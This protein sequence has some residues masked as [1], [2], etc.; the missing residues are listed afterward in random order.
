[1]SK[2]KEFKYGDNVRVK[3]PGKRA[4][5]GKVYSQYT[6]PPSSRYI[7]VEHPGGAGIAYLVRYVTNLT[8]R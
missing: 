3:E 8:A 1:M 2:E 5:I 7:C 6:Q 4:F